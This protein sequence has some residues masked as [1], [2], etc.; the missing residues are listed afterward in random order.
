[1]LTILVKLF[2]YYVFCAC[3]IL[4]VCIIRKLSPPDTWPHHMRLASQC[5]TLLSQH[6][7]QASFARR[8]GIFLGELRGDA[9]K[10]LEQWDSDSS[11]ERDEQRGL[12]KGRGEAG[13]VAREQETGSFEPGLDLAAMDHASVSE[14]FEDLTNWEE[15][16]SFVSCFRFAS[17]QRVS[18]QASTQLGV[19]WNVF[20]LTI[21]FQVMAGMNFDFDV[22]FDMTST[23]NFDDLRFGEDSNTAGLT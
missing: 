15:L 14:L 20:A 3:A 5:Q 1:M 12:V 9:E 11:E 19:L 13:S 18:L 4:Y 22:G 21:R 10:K 23:T 2:Q 7:H 16:D 6:A 17:S 8:Y